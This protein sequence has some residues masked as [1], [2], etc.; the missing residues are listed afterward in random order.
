MP[1]ALMPALGGSNAS[2]TTSPH[3]F[4][5]SKDWFDRYSKQFCLQNIKKI[6]EVA[7]A[8]HEVV[9]AFLPEL[10][11]IIEEK[12][13]RPEQVWNVDENAIQDVYHDGGKVGVRVQGSKGL[14][15]LAGLWQC[16]RP[17]D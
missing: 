16:C 10:K 3:P 7:S 9:V 5:A 14:L 8:D 12:G 6:K 17:Y 11:S 1:L 13:Y 15:H 4:N 2:P